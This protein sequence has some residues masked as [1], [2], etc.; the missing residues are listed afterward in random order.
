MGTKS[1]ML[2]ALALLQTLC[3]GACGDDDESSDRVGSACTAADQCYRDLD[4]MVAGAAVC[5]DRVEG[6]YCSH[7]CRSDGDCCAVEGECPNGEEQV[8]GPF[9]STGQMLCFLS[10]EGQQDGDAYCASY[11]HEGFTCRSTGGGAKNRKVCIPNG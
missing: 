10:C 11:A 1:S 5:L 3:T 9:E 6:G 7:Q 8:C 4:R 2:C